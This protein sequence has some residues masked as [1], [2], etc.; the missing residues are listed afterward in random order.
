MT[1]DNDLV[2]YTFRVTSSVKS[3]YGSHYNTQNVLDFSE[4]LLFHTKEA[5]QTAAEGIVNSLLKTDGAVVKSRIY[6]EGEFTP[7]LNRS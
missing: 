2:M 1:E 4:V 3:S 5:A 7:R 6:T